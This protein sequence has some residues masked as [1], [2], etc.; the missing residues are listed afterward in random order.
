M[1]PNFDRKFYLQTDA[2][3]YSMGAVL[4]QDGGNTT[5][6]LLKRTKPTLHPI[7]YYSATFTPTE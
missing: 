3:A 6:S 2:S 5:P 1:Q 4:L 7:T